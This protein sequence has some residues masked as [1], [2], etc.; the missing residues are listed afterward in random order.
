MGKLLGSQLHLFLV[1]AASVETM[2]TAMLWIHIPAPAR[3]ALPMGQPAYPAPR[4]ISPEIH[5][6]PAGQSAV[7]SPTPPLPVG[8][9]KL[10]FRGHRPVFVRHLR[11]S[12]VHILNGFDPQWTPGAF[13]AIS[14]SLC[15]WAGQCWD[16]DGTLRPGLTVRMLGLDQ[17]SSVGLFAEQE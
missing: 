1:D 5:V 2:A 9:C 7:S 15:R 13:G 6:T 14:F 10:G 12:A 4:L 3:A 8:E 17:A 11:I 16:M